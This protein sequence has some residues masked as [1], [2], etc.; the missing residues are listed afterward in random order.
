MS[1]DQLA[2]I[3]SL[4]GGNFNA[5]TRETLTQYLFTVPSDDLDVA[6]HIE[7]ERM[8]DV[9]DNEKDWTEERG[10]IGHLKMTLERASNHTQIISRM[11]LV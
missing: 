7:A 5:S 4:M 3:S 2:D 8:T 11:G 6:L 1:A 9:N 10:A